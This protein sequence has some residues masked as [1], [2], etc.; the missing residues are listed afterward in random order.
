MP[1]YLMTLVNRKQRD[2][3]FNSCPM[4]FTR[5]TNPK[6]DKK[7]GYILIQLSHKYSSSPWGIWLFKPWLTLHSYLCHICK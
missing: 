4:Q 5:T 6:Y 1:L 2:Y 7:I 3:I